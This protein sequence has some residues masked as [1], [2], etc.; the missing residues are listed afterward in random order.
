MLVA[1]F[2]WAQSKPVPRGVHQAEQASQQSEKNVPPPES[3][4]RSD[5]HQQQ[6]DADELARLAESLPRDLEQVNRG[7]L[8][9]DVADKLKR[10][11]KLAKKL[12][13]ELSR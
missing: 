5:P 2:A 3:V 4:S 8:P 7:L 11:E 1:P 13:G 10:I 6:K 12:R 9:K